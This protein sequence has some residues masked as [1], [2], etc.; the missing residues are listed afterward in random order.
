MAVCRL[1]NLEARL[2][3][4]VLPIFANANACPCLCGS[5]CYYPLMT[6]T[7]KYT[8]TSAS[9]VELGTYEAATPCEALNEMA[10]DAGY[11]SHEEACDVTGS[12]ETS[13]TTDLEAFK[14]HGY[15]L[16]VVEASGT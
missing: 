6:T 15:E 10:M 4:I 2:A 7:N 8:I 9:G 12:D 3:Y 1:G 5:K 14:R 13:W 16:L 11:R